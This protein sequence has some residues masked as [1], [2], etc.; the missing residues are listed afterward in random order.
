MTHTPATQTDGNAYARHTLLQSLRRALGAIESDLEATRLNLSLSQDDYQR[1]VDFFLTA[2][3]EAASL[4]IAFD[5]ETQRRAALA[6]E[7]VEEAASGADGSD[8]MGGMVIG[9][10][11]GIANLLVAQTDMVELP[12]DLLTLSDGTAVGGDYEPV[13]ILFA[14]DADDWYTDTYYV[15]GTVEAVNVESGHALVSYR[16]RFSGIARAW[17]FDAGRLVSPATVNAA[18]GSDTVHGDGGTDTSAIAADVDYVI[19][20][21]YDARLFVGENFIVVNKDSHEGTRVLGEIYDSGRWTL[22]A[23]AGDL[24]EYRR[25]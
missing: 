11:R 17:W 4:I 7:V 14:A 10:A 9:A 1:D 12:F 13:V 8:G 23:A 21:R 16:D 6:P 20:T 2:A 15:D 18:V 5:L 24:T 19:V 22:T 25:R 3:R